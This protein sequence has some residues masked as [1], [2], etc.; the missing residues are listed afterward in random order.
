MMVIHVC[1]IKRDERNGDKKMNTKRDD[2]ADTI[3]MNYI[4]I[5]AN[6]RHLQM[7]DS[8]VL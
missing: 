2:D 6:P 4:Q 8:T 1:D 5:S 7:S 3:F